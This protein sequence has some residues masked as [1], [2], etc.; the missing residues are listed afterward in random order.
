[1]AISSE[2]SKRFDHFRRRLHQLDQHAFAAD[3]K[4][5]VALGVYKTNIKTGSAFANSTGRKTQTL[6]AQPFNSFG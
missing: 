2:C 4:F 5:F 6:S 1:M 3:R